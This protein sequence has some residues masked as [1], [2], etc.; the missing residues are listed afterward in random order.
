MRSV[1]SIGLI[2]PSIGGIRDLNQGHV[3]C[4]FARISDGRRMV[5]AMVVGL[6]AD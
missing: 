3:E 5:M 1:L 2:A 4:R 6:A